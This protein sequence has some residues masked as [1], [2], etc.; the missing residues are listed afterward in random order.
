MKK[1]DNLVALNLSVNVEEITAALLLHLDYD[2]LISMIKVIDLHVADVDFTEQ[3]ILMLTK[4]FK[5]DLTV[6]EKER[7]MVAIRD[8]MR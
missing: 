3:L 5:N 7:F 4:S 1:K 6:E 2:E 8:S